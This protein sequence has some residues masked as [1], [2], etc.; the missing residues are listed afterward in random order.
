MDASG[1]GLAPHLENGTMLANFRIQQLPSPF[2]LSE[3]PA[4]AEIKS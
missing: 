1:F 4:V 3:L 2:F